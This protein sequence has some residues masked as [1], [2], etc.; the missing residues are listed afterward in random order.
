MTSQYVDGGEISGGAVDSCCAMLPKASSHRRLPSG[1]LNAPRLHHSHYVRIHVYTCSV[2]RSMMMQ[3]NT[4]V[5]SD[6]AYAFY[7]L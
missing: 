6:S 3:S 4:L 5:S 1:L 2:L 7:D